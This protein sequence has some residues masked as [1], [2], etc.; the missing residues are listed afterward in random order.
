MIKKKISKIL[1]PLDGSKNSLRGLEMAISLARNCGAT[2]TG[3]YSLYAPP[4]SEF[5]GVGSVEKALNTEVK[6]FMDEA[7]TLSAQNGIVFN[8]KIMS[9]EIGYNIIKLAHGKDNF[10]MIVIGSRG[11]SATKEMFFGSVSNYVIHT[12]KIPV[13]IVK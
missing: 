13:V 11:R 12:S 1:V 5:K 10:D 6:K 8:Q 2:L 9:G 7:K 4:H 3:V